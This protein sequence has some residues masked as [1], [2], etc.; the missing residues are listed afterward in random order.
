MMDMKEIKLSKG[1]KVKFASEKQHFTVR[2]ANDR[3][4]ICTKPFNLR[5]TVIYT[6]VDKKLQIRGADDLIFGMGYETDEQCKDALERL[7]R[8]EAAVSR[9]KFIPLDI[10]LVSHA[11]AGR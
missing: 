7:E 2:E 1:D 5:R 3:F 4:A 8:G 10:I 11:R 9:K 6:I